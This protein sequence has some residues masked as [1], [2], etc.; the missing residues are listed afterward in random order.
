MKSIEKNISLI[1]SVLIVIPIGFIYGFQ[2][3]LLFDIQLNTIDE[4][5][6]FKAIMGLYFGFSLLWILGVFKNKFWQIAIF[7]NFIFMF[8]LA[9]GRIVSILCDG[10]PSSLFVLGTFGELILG[11]YSLIIWKR[12]LSDKNSI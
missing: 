1:F 3:N 2:P 5:G 9:F 10:I 8:G 7:S 12:L 11:F 4:H 6:V